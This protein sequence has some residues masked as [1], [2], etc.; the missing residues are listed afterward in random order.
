MEW[1]ERHGCWL[2]TPPQPKG[3]I[4]FLGGAFVATAPQVTYSRLLTALAQDGFLIIATPFINTVDHR[5]IATEIYWKLQRTLRYLQ[6]YELR[7]R[8]LPIYGLGH[9]MGCKMHLLICSE[10]AVQRAGN[11]LIS[12]NNFPV[13]KSIPFAEMLAPS[14]GVEF[15]PSPREF[16]NLVEDDYPI[17]R[18]LLIQFSQDELDQTNRL[19][20]LLK[21]RFPGLITQLQLRGTH[22][23]P[24]G[25]DF[26]WPIGTTFTPWDVVGQWVR[27]SLFQDLADLENQLL[28]WLD[29]Y[30]RNSNNAILIK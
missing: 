4:H 7:G 19:A 8:D 27:Q 20:F 18:N 29:P 9:S 5:A 11:I 10:F 22:V 6:E 14:L 28:S 3:I 21:A 25:A 17:P 26:K 12:F 16:M 23:T 2:L 15:I 13:E 30:G 1:W 24:M